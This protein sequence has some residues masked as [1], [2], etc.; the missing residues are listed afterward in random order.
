MQSGESRTEGRCFSSLIAILTKRFIKVRRNVKHTMYFR[1]ISGSRQSRAIE[2]VEAMLE[3]FQSCSRSVILVA[4]R[5]E[6]SL[7][8]R[9]E[10]VCS[11]HNKTYSA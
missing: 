6:L 8:Y 7:V 10:G 11:S 5:K 2:G 3:G 9:S 4:P 1:L